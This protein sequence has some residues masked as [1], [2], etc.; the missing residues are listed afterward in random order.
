MK[1]IS[2]MIKDIFRTKSIQIGAFAAFFYYAAVVVWTYLDEVARIDSAASNRFGARLSSQL[3]FAEVMDS[4]G[5]PYF[6]VIL[7][8]LVFIF[9]PV[10][11]IVYLV[12]KNIRDESHVGWRR[13]AVVASLLIVMW[14]IFVS[15]SGFPQGAIEVVLSA[16]L[17]LVLIAAARWVSLGFMDKR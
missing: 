8:S 5:F 12:G 1:L 14:R 13:L 7:L 10:I 2:P 3:S 6:S 9:L 16:L 15:R 17:G 4:S 11:F